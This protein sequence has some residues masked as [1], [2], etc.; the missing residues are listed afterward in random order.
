MNRGRVHKP[1]RINR[2]AKGHIANRDTLETSGRHTRAYYGCP[3]E[4]VKSLSGKYHPSP[5]KRRPTPTAPHGGYS[6]RR[7]GGSPGGKTSGT[8]S[9]SENLGNRSFRSP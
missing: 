3:K 8:G 9:G 4:N 6:E 5:A 1:G 7:T 2:R